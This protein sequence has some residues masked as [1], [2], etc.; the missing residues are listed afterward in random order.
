MDLLK[1]GKFRVRKEC[2]KTSNLRPC[3]APSDV[4]LADGSGA[5]SGRPFLRHSPPP[6]NGHLHTSRRHHQHFRSWRVNRT[7]V[8]PNRS[9][10]VM[11]DS[12][13]PHI[14]PVLHTRSIYHL[15]FLHSSDTNFSHVYRCSSTREIDFDLLAQARTNCSQPEL[16][17]KNRRKLNVSIFTYTGIT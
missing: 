5:Q 8:G 2:L 14:R 13:W 11:E 3:K 16:K 17:K 7:R 10:D 15:S 1:R 9:G 12:N 6:R 4:P